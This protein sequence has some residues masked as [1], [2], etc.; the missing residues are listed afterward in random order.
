MGYTM[1]VRLGILIAA[2][3]FLGSAAWVGALSI[4]TYLDP[5]GIPG[6][7]GVSG[8]FAIF[9]LAM[10]GFLLRLALFPPPYARRRRRSGR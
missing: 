9:L 7:V 3:G 4:R 5:S 1:V 6:V 10:G 8:V 2:C